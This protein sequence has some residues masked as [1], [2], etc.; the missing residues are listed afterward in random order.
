MKKIYLVLIAVTLVLTSCNKNILDLK[1]YDKLSDAAIWADI[2]LVQ[3]YVTENY[4]SISMATF[5]FPNGFGSN[6]T[7]W[8]NY[9]AVYGYWTGAAVDEIFEYPI[10]P[11]V[12][13][14]YPRGV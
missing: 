6:N 11:V 9:S 7:G 2:N 10:S 4:N 8:G 13:I 14:L 12:I 5:G 3:G 1:P